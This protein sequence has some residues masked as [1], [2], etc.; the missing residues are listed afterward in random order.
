MLVNPPEGRTP[1]DRERD[2]IYLDQRGDLQDTA[3]KKVKCVLDLPG[4]LADVG[5]INYT[6]VGSE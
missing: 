4:D 5:Q 3:D 1:T 2:R 6:T